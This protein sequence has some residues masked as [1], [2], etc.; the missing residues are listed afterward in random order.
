MT[1][2]SHAPRT[3]GITGGYDQLKNLQGPL[4]NMNAPPSNAQGFNVVDQK[5]GA[6]AGGPPAIGS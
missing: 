1:Q 6:A 5:A 2:S 4:L 3:K